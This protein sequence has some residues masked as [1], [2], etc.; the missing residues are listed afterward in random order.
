MLRAPQDVIWHHPAISEEYI[1]AELDG[2]HFRINLH[3]DPFQPPAHAL[4][5]LLV[6]AKNL[7]SVANIER[8]FGVGGFHEWYFGHLLSPDPLCIY[9]PNSN[10]STREGY[11]PAYVFILL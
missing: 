11:L 9:V 4:S 6:I 1:R 3:D 8:K 2:H 5:V 7:Y 10:F